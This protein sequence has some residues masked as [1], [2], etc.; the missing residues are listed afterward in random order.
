MAFVGVLLTET[1]HKTAGSAEQD[2]T[3]YT[4]RMILLNTFGKID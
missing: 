4:C 2:Q 3:A 1:N